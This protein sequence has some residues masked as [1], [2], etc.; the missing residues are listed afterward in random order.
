M[1]PVQVKPRGRS[2]YQISAVGPYAGGSS[3]MRR[4]RRWPWAVG[5]VLALVLA[6][7]AFAYFAWPKGGLVADPAALARVTAPSLGG[8]TKVSAHAADGTAIPLLANRVARPASLFVSSSGADS[9]P[10]RPFCDC[11]RPLASAVFSQK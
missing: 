6:A 11:P 2:V 10:E 8:S 4:R 5:L 3:R 7:L 9:L 1:A